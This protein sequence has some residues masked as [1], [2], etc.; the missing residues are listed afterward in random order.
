MQGVI[1]GA[2]SE[3]EVEDLAMLLG[4]GALPPGVRLIEQRLTGSGTE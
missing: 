4:A 3:Q 2:F 1:Q